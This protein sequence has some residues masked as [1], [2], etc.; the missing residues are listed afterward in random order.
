LLLLT[1]TT[2]RIAIA[3][4][5]AG[6]THT[7]GIGCRSTATAATRRRC[8]ATAVELVASFL[9]FSSLQRIRVF[10]RAKHKA[11]IGIFAIGCAL[12]ASIV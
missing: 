4:L 8:V 6:C 3:I 10:G 5:D 2:V 7:G 9:V 12:T 1:R 11:Q